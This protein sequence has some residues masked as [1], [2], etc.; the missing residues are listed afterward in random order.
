MDVLSRIE[1][2]ATCAVI[3]LW[4][5]ERAIFSGAGWKLARFEDARLVEIYDPSGLPYLGDMQ[6]MADNA[7]AA[8]SAWLAT[9]EGETFLVLCCAHQ[10]LMPRPIALGDPASLANMSRLLA[11]EISP[12]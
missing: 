8:A 1:L 9:A 3:N 7:L 12:F 2:S 11:G 10:L 6:A 5:S 4:E